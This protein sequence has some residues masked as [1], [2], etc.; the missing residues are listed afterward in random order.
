MSPGVR[1]AFETLRAGEA[2]REGRVFAHLS[3]KGFGHDALDKA[4]LRDHVWHSNRH[5]FCTRLT[6]RG[7]QLR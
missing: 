3:P 1:A 4:K 5:T 7:V 2:K 6:E